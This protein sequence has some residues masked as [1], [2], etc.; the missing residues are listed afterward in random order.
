[1][2]NKK[3]GFRTSLASEI[4]KNTNIPI[5]TS[6]NLKNLKIID[7]D[8]LSG[9]YD[10]VAIG[11][12]FLKNPFWLFDNKNFKK[13]LNMICLIKLIEALKKNDLK[14]LSFLKIHFK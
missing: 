14:I 2:N 3:K 7:K 1:M 10:L 6:G 5:R 13:N 11:R 12:P 9:K 8:I 4:K